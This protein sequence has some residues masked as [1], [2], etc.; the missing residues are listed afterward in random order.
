ME[1]NHTTA[2]KA[3][4]SVNRSILSGA[5]TCVG[6]L[7]PPMG[8]RN[9]VGIGLSYRPASLCTL[10]PRFLESIPRLRAGLKLSTLVCVHQS[11]S[12]VMGGGGVPERNL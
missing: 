7:S 3:L 10:A 4:V 5:L 11:T 8:A 6:N 1:P 2:E 9:K 12:R